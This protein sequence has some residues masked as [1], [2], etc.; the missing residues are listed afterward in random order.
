MV[1]S[2][3]PKARP[4]PT[5][6][7]IIPTY[8]RARLVTQAL[9]SVLNQTR[10]PD[11]VVVVDDGSTDDTPVVL[12]SYGARIRYMRQQNSGKPAAVNRAMATVEA[13]YVW[14]MDDDDVALPD[15]LERQ[16]ACLRV[17]PEVDFT[18]S[19]LYAFTGEG[20]PPPV[21]QCRFWQYPDVPHAGLF[22]HMME[23]AQPN[24]Q[25]MLVPR[26]CYEAV[27]P[28]DETLTFCEDYEIILR[29]A[30]RFRG[31]R[32]SRPAV[33]YREHTGTR[34]PAHERYA[35]SERKK[36]WLIYEKKIFANLYRT[37]ALSEYLPRGPARLDADPAKTGNSLTDSQTRRALLQRASIM[38]RHGVFEAALED[39][40]A[41]TAAAQE[42]PFC[43]EERT[44]CRRMLE[45][46]PLLAGQDSFI[47]SAGKLLQD[48]AAGLHE[49]A[50]AGF[51]WRLWGQLRTGDLRSAV[52]NGLQLLH[53]TGPVALLG[54]FARRLKRRMAG[55][56]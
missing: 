24:H 23:H 19:G 12:D 27:G 6:A 29:L 49:I 46:D 45:I 50:A 13:D 35:A 3:Q 55:P 53:F 10:P 38:A 52:R 39:F 8:N 9:D 36:G 34:G 32:L 54:M 14:I 43:S 30:R 37:L 41:A 25:T 56:G 21:D 1:N 48:R 40:E 28:L 16:F 20:P 11:E 51:I 5:V 44:M 26:A 17:H 31:G 7:V 33:F 47:R 42:V 22:I 4:G 2:A 15:A 18:Y